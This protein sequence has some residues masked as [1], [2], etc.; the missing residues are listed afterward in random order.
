ME[1]LSLKVV[2]L[3][4]S[5]N[6]NSR[7]TIA[8]QQCLSFI[9][10]SGHSTH[11]F[12]LKTKNIPFF[13]EANRQVS[14]TAQ[15]MIDEIR[16]AD[17]LIIATPEY[18]GSYSGVLK[19][20]LDYLTKSEVETKAIGL[21]G[22]GA[23]QYGGYSAIDALANV[24]KT[25]HGIVLPLQVSLSNSHVVIQNNQVQCEKHSYRLKLLAEQVIHYSGK[26]RNRAA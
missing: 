12:D 22:V 5:L 9:E 21:I 23:G 25:L 16:T 6:E 20:A 3:S 11:L 7:T 1:T 26:L 4:G 10:A 18:H 13:S 17:A 8:L 15:A 14:L 24:M 2:G 19:N